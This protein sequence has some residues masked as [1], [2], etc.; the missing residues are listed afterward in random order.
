M[1][2][3]N[4]F[5]DFKKQTVR[6]PKCR[7]GKKSEPLWL[8]FSFLL[9]EIR[10]FGAEEDLFHCSPAEGDEGV[11]VVE[12]AEDGVVGGDGEEEDEHSD[13]EAPDAEEEDE[14]EGEHS[15]KLEG[16]AELIVLLGEVCDGDECH[17]EYHVFAEPADSDG[18]V[19]EQERS[20]HRERV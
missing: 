5:S 19:A 8:A 15:H 16:V 20:D 18:K 12:S 9:L 6:R 4:S 13:S 7:N 10:L 14:C 3:K 11:E 1:Q 17:I 2:R